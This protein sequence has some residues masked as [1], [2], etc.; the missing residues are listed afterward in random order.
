MPDLPIY[1]YETLYKAHFEALDLGIS[2]LITP[3]TGDERIR[4]VDE[5]TRGFVYM[6]SSA[7]I[8]GG[9]QSGI[10]EE[11]LTYFN[12][13]NDMQLKH[14]RLIGF[15][16]S[17]HQSF[18]TACNYADGAI[19]GSAFIRAL[20]EKGDLEEKVNGFVQKILN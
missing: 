18:S 20:T 12:R 3:Q 8:T 9:T 13:I 16:I 5:L 17:D 1:E 15:G 4:K 7:S 14:P 11:Q 10:S 2:F 6:V 19:I